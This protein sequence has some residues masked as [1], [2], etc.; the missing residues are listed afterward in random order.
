MPIK[1][2]HNPPEPPSNPSGL[3]N[4]QLGQ[5]LWRGGQRSNQWSPQQFTQ[6]YGN[7]TGMYP[8]LGQQVGQALQGS[9]QSEYM[10][11]AWAQSVLPPRADRVQDMGAYNQLLYSKPDPIRGGY[12]PNPNR[13][14][15]VGNPYPLNGALPQDQRM[16]G[17]V[18]TANNPF[19]GAYQGLTGYPGGQVQPG[20]GPPTTI[21]GPPTT[22]GNT[23]GQQSNPF[24]QFQ[25]AMKSGQISPGMV[26]GLLGMFSRGR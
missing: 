18:S 23:L 20:G 10:R 4:I 14:R 5:T 3:P 16:I 11:P 13:L 24:A 19:I 2:T 7:Y 8:S 1:D 12:S 22:P 15:Q 21:G 6:T 9:I 17:R 26:Q 25:S